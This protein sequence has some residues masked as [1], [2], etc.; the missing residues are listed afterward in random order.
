MPELFVKFILFMSIA[1]ARIIIYFHL[2]TDTLIQA[3]I[4]KEYQTILLQSLF[5][6]IVTNLL[7]L[8]FFTL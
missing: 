6:C 1:M 5:F 2:N 7:R 3:F 8:S 4:F